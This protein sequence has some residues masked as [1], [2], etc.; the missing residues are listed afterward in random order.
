MKFAFLLAAAC[1]LTT[2]TFSLA[3]L[4]E[5][6]VLV[7]SQGQHL[8]VNLPQ[9]RLFLYQDGELVR[10]YP[11]AVGKVVTNTPIGNYAV[12]GIYHDPVW[13]IPKSIQEEMARQ[14]KPVQTTVAAGPDNPL[15]PV[16]VRFG[17]ARL[18]L[19]FHGTNQPG[20]VPGFR[21]HGCVRLRSENALALAS[22]VNIG[23]AVTIS[24]QT[25]LLNEDDAGEL[26]LHVYRDPYKND[27]SPTQLADTLLEWQ[28]RN[29]RPLHGARVDQA[30]RERTGKPVC[31]SCDKARDN[32]ISGNLHTLR[33]L[34]P[35]AEPAD[36][37]APA[38]QTGSSGKRPLRPPLA[39][40]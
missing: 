20:S 11:V 30:F 12:T 36:V 4:P 35:P 25:V 21:S 8:V 38:Q 9:T 5:P 33:W 31:L 14:G 26:W 7:S 23:A 27:S 34:T 3:A 29:A 39:R 37:A 19:G 28:Q 13:H 10:S 15:G 1:A 24:Y 17:E 2:A 16:F 18:G 6:D 40:L 22:W 32:S